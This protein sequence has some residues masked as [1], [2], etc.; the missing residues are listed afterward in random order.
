LLQSSPKHSKNQALAG[1]DRTILNQ[2]RLDPQNAGLG[3]HLERTLQAPEV[4]EIDLILAGGRI[5]GSGKLHHNSLLTLL[6]GGDEL[7][8]AVEFL[9]LFISGL[10]E[11]K[12]IAVL[13]AAAGNNLQR[14]IASPD[15]PAWSPARLSK[16]AKSA[17]RRVFSSSRALIC[18][19]ES[20]LCRTLDAQAAFARIRHL[21][22]A[23]QFGFLSGQALAHF[24]DFMFAGDLVKAGKLPSGVVNPAGQ[25]QRHAGR[26][27][28]MASARQY[29]GKCVRIATRGAE[30]PKRPRSRRSV[31]ARRE[32]AKGLNIRR[33]Q[34]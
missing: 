19:G 24:G 3:S 25:R 28:T 6:H 11:K 20:F 14:L 1:L 17:L 22:R 29:H 7:N 10:G 30:M 13:S 34:T 21:A 12:T 27:T 8:H 5:A 23:L 18:C 4:A 33:D 26:R 32:L 2:T 31:R 9:V 15:L 16:V